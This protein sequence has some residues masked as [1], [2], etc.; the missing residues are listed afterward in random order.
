MS[1]YFIKAITIEDFLNEI[2]SCIDSKNFLSAFY[3]T[4]ALPDICSRISKELNDSTSRTAKYESWFNKWVYRKYYSMPKGKYIR[5]LKSCNPELYRIKFNGAICYKLRCSILH[6]GN[7]NLEIP[8]KEKDKLK[9]KITSI[10]LCLN[11]KSDFQYGE[12]T[13]IVKSNN[14]KEISLRINII[15]L[16]N[17]MISGCQDFL[18]YYNLKNHRLF[19]MIDW[20]FNPII[21]EDIF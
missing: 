10:E 19:N 12:S 1:E 11:S 5:R 16:M 4:L 17:N 20:D 2:K 3:M 9:M 6:H 8:S 14:K 7:I 21:H 15:T 18:E 13:S